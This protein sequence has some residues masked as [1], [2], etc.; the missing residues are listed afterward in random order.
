M[1]HAMGQCY[2]VTKVIGGCY[3]LSIPT[4]HMGKFSPH[5]E[6]FRGGTGGTEKVVDLSSGPQ[7]PCQKLVW[8]YIHVNPV[9]GRQINQGTPSSVRD[10]A[11]KESSGK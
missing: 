11:S 6:V 5:R 8:L 7:L 10:P 3:G 9:L 1:V 2:A 4:K